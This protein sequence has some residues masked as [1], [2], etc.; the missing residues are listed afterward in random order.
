MSSY[1]V[2]YIP[3]GEYFLNDYDY[4]E[5]KKD[6]RS[7]ASYGE[8]IRILDDYPNLEQKITELFWDYLKEIG[9]TA[10]FRMTTSW[11]TKINKGESIKAHS[12]KNCEFSGVLYYDDDYTDQTPLHFANPLINL[13]QFHDA[14]AKPTGYTNDWTLEPEKNLLIFFPSYI[15]HYSEVS[16]SDKPRRS[17]AFNFAPSGTYGAGDSTMNTRWLNS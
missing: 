10:Y 14:G 1:P 11:L 12:H 15:S 6:T 7:Q 13:T 16:K 17:L 8:C 2:F 4:T 3:F 5:L 9:F